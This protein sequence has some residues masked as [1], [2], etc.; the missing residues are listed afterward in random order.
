VIALARLTNVADALGCSKHIGFGD[1]HRHAHS[2]DH[3]SGPSAKEKPG[4]HAR[5]ILI[6]KL[7]ARAPTNRLKVAHGQAHRIASQVPWIVH[8]SLVAFISPLLAT[9]RLPDVGELR[10]RSRAT[11]LSYINFFHG[12]H[13]V[14]V[15]R[16]IRS[17]FEHDFSND[18][19]S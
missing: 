2:Q 14:T 4:H 15:L 13:L 5:H 3:D 19:R 1:H 9:E 17:Y 10:R 7:L 11:S 12:H 18:K 6:L 16:T 8:A